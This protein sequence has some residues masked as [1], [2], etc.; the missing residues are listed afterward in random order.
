MSFKKK[1]I[2]LGGKINL[3]GEKYWV[4]RKQKYDE[5]FAG[6]FTSVMIQVF[7]TGEC[8]I[9]CDNDA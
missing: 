7:V 5:H 8:D 1:C 3:L 4:V 9:V 6:M 2:Q